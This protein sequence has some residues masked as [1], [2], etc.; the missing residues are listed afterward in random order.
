MKTISV[1][2][3][4]DYLTC[5]MSWDCNHSIELKNLSH[6]LWDFLWLLSLW[7]ALT[8]VKSLWLKNLD[9]SHVMYSSLKFFPHGEGIWV[10]FNYSHTCQLNCCCVEAVFTQQLCWCDIAL[11]NT[12]DSFCPIWLALQCW[13]TQKQTAGWAGWGWTSV[14]PYV[15]VPSALLTSFS[16]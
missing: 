2:K 6:T 4:A 9:H 12:D 7:P 10:F 3:L 11:I 8:F 5:L 13:K 1:W 14:C 15:C 16:P